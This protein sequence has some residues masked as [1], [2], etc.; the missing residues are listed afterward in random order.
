MFLQFRQGKHQILILL[1]EY[2]TILKT[3][4]QTSGE[5]GH[6]INGSF[7]YHIANYLKQRKY[8]FSQ[9]HIFFFVVNI[10]KQLHNCNLLQQNCNGMCI[11]I[12]CNVYCVCIVWVRFPTG[13]LAFSITGYRAS[14]TRYPTGYRLSGQPDIWCI[15]S[16]DVAMVC[17]FCVYYVC[18][19]FRLGKHIYSQLLQVLYMY[20]V[21]IGQRYIGIVFLQCTLFRQ[22]T[23]YWY[24]CMFVNCSDWATEYNVGIM[25]EYCSNWATVYKNYVCIL[26]RLGIGITVGTVFVYCSDWVTV[27]VQV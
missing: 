7:L 25:S 23:V 10:C 1:G 19:L 27:C 21:P 18:M 2:W 13:Y 6:R 15:T 8:I 12:M 26:F 24:Y 9:N 22:A 4:S 17:R 11:G 5:A 20:T 3:R 14:H 16:S